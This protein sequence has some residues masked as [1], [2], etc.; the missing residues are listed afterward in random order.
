MSFRLIAVK[1]CNGTFMISIKTTHK[2]RCYCRFCALFFLLWV[3]TINGFTLGDHNQWVQFKNQEKLYYLTWPGVP[4]VTWPGRTFGHVTGTC[5]WSCDQGTYCWSRDQ[6]VQLILTRAQTKWLHGASV[7]FPVGAGT[8]CCHSCTAWLRFVILSRSCLFPLQS[9][10]H[11]IV[12]IQSDCTVRF[13][14]NIA[15]NY[16]RKR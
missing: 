15:V 11:F 3:T 1:N 12:F 14:C 5:C 2:K 6:D 4:L 10:P 7:C 16:D 9:L 13:Q 8:T